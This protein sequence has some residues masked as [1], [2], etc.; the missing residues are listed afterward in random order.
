MKKQIG[1]AAR[2][3]LFDSH[4]PV[5]FLIYWQLVIANEMIV[6]EVEKV[7]LPIKQS[8]QHG[9]C[10]HTTYNE[11]FHHSSNYL[12]AF[13]IISTNLLKEFYM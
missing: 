9:F 2:T 13:E 12:G 1:A 5:L 8:A 3:P 4:N 7:D 10:H 6:T 11:G